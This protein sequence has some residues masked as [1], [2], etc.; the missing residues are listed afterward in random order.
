MASV[1]GPGTAPRRAP[2][3]APRWSWGSFWRSTCWR[4]SSWWWSAASPTARATSA[5][6]DGGGAGPHFSK[7][8][9]RVAPLDVDTVTWAWRWPTRTRPSSPFRS[10]SPPTA[11]G[12]A[13]G[14]WLGGWAARHGGG[15]DP[16]RTAPPLLAVAGVGV[17]AAGVLGSSRGA[18]RMIARETHNK[19]EGFLDRLEHGELRLPQQK[20]DCRRGSGCD[21]SRRRVPAGSSPRVPPR[22]MDVRSSARVA[23]RSG[24][25]GWL[26]KLSR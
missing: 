23:R 3:A 19:L 7:V 2:S 14:G 17:L 21:P 16:G 11:H 18:Y 22:P 25:Y 15:G 9:S 4:W 1:M 13:A 12:T 5:R 10:T 8:G 26:E 20:Q 6:G 24:G